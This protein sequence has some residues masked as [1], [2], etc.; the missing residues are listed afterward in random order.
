[1]SAVSETVDYQLRK[2]YASIDKSYQYIRIMPQLFTADAELDNVSDKN[3]E[4]LNQA[5]IQNVYDMDGELDRIAKLLV[6]NGR[7]E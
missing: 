7:V 2:L 4:E 3:I 5:G 6:E 1:M